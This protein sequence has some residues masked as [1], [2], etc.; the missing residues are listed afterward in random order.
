MAQDR[1]GYANGLPTHVEV[2]ELYKLT[3]AAEQIAFELKMLR[4]LLQS[5]VNSPDIRGHVRAESKK[6]YNDE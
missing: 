1:D 5:V 3:S 2:D 4:T 6:F